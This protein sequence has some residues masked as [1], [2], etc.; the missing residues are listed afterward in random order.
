ME[1]IKIDS[2]IKK[3]FD[4]IANNTDKTVNVCQK[5]VQEVHKNSENGKAQ[6]EPYLD[7]KNIEP[8]KTTR[9]GLEFGVVTA[10][11]TE[12]KVRKEKKHGTTRFICPAWSW[13]L[14]PNKSLTFKGQPTKW[15]HCFVRRPQLS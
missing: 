2:A 10:H 13:S 11:D 12:F 3:Q 7:L 8:A 14:S 15:R 6:V 4:N 5:I 9:R 1:E